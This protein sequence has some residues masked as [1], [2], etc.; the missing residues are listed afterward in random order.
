[1]IPLPTALHDYDRLPQPFALTLLECRPRISDRSELTSAGLGIRLRP[2]FDPGKADHRAGVLEEPVR[3][4]V[5]ASLDI[6]ADRA[7]LSRDGASEAALLGFDRVARV[8]VELVVKRILKFHDTHNLPNIVAGDVSMA[9]HVQAAV[10][11]RDLKGLALTAARE[12]AGKVLEVYSTSLEI[13]APDLDADPAAIP[14]QALDR[15]LTANAEGMFGRNTPGIRA[16]SGADLPEGL[17]YFAPRI[18]AVDGEAAALAAVTLLEEI[19]RIARNLDPG[20]IEVVWLELF[21]EQIL[22]LAMEDDFAFDEEFQRSYHAYLA[23][24]P[25]TLRPIK[26]IKPA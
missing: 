3:L 7:A 8:L 5:H 21:V 17:C 11:L 25:G 24:R 26:S 12:A 10:T 20:D 23:V 9:R 13:E 2:D 14:D 16:L 18:A 22:I 15:P 19:T 1:M 6:A 4:M